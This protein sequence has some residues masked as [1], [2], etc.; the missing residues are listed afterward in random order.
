MAKTYKCYLWG[1]SIFLLLP[2]DELSEQ[3]K[4]VKANIIGEISNMNSLT[5]SELQLKCYND[6]TGFESLSSLMHYYKNN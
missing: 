1:N 6:A 4:Y 5:V 3:P 2:R